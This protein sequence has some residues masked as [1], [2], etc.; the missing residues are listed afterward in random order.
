[1]FWRRTI[2][3]VV[4]S[5]SRL[6]FLSLDLLA[7]QTLCRQLLKSYIN[8]HNLL[9]LRLL[10]LVC[11]YTLSL[12]AIRL[13]S[14]TQTNDPK[15]NLLNVCDWS[16]S[17]VVALIWMFVCLSSLPRPINWEWEYS[18]EDHPTCCRAQRK[19]DDSPRVNWNQQQQLRVDH[20]LHP[21][22]SKTQVYYLSWIVWMLL[23]WW[24]RTRDW[25]RWYM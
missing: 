3:V 14:T 22:T 18:N 7:T 8:I 20:Y 19:K 1:M 17:L 21:S 15:S 5:E 2:R 11:K 6:L 4:L 12:S 23:V 16:L 9:T 24:S 25:D 10:L 13:N